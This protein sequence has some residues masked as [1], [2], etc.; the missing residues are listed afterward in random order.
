MKLSRKAVEG[1]AKL[2]KKFGVPAAANVALVL[3]GVRPAYRFDEDP[4]WFKEEG[5]FDDPPFRAR[6]QEAWTRN[7]EDFVAFVRTTFKGVL[8]CVDQSE[9]LAYRIGAVSASDLKAIARKNDSTKSAAKAYARALNFTGT[10][11]PCD[12]YKDRVHV[13]WLFFD[14]KG[15][16]RSLSNYCAFPSEVYACVREFA[17]MKKR[18]KG[19]IGVKFGDFEIAELAMSFNLEGDVLV[20]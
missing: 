8:E 14:G 4:L 2:S 15:D 9:P 20:R 6:L 1:V 19:V 18:A 13:T 3:A 7:C 11:Y 16:L 10:A 5:D 17:A 12:E